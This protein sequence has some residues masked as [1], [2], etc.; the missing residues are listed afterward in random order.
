MADT[1]PHLDALAKADPTKLKQFAETLIGD[2]GDIEVLHSRT[3]LVMLP[4]RDTAQGTVFH[5]GEVL[6]SEAHIRA[7][8]QEGYGLRRGHDLEASMAMALID[9]AI[10]RGIQ[11]D[12]CTKFCEAARH[13]QSAQDDATLRRVEA[14][15]VN[16]ETF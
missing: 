7:D 3:G 5:L 11:A 2:L 13:T 1:D 6:V 14:T 12:I 8:A 16:M 4:M 9:L 10:K 15:R